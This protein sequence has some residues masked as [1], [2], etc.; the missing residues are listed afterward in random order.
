MNLKRMLIVLIVYIFSNS[1]SICCC[2][3]FANF[4]FLEDA[5][6]DADLPLFFVDL[7]VTVV[8]IFLVIFF[9]GIIQKEEQKKEE[10]KSFIKGPKF[11]DDKQK[12][13]ENKNKVKSKKHST[14]YCTNSRNKIKI[15]VFICFEN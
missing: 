3:A 4:A 9:L 14:L 6:T 2:S 15:F 13:F 10:K 8:D 1:S 7:D 11:I 12:K 5:S